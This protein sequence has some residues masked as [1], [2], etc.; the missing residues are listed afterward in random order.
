M[1]SQQL[2]GYVECFQVMSH[3]VLQAHQLDVSRSPSY[4]TKPS[5]SSWL[6][7]MKSCF[8]HHSLNLFFCSFSAFTLKFKLLK[9]IKSLFS[10]NQEL[11]Y[12]I[13]A[14]L[15]FL[16]PIIC[17]FPI[18]S[19]SLS[20]LLLMVAFFVVHQRLALVSGVRFWRKQE[21]GPSCRAAWPHHSHV[22]TLSLHRL[23]VIPAPPDKFTN[24]YFTSRLHLWNHKPVR[25]QT[26]ILPLSLQPSPTSAF[27]GKKPELNLNENTSPSLS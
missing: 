4:E 3:R 2:N 10:I 26:A 18:H 6:W 17:I 11:V 13:S 20:S 5:G 23:S 14:S 22:D 24:Q 7:S 21:S 27:V 1:L 15:D 8:C 25:N 19:V 16:F 9:H 12:N